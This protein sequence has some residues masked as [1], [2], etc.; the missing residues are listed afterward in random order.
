MA[1]EDITIA[2]IQNGVKKWQVAE[3]LGIWDSSFSRILRTELKAE[4]KAK[5]MQV[6]NDLKK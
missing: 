6:I 4:D 2:C 1:N 3:K 5:I